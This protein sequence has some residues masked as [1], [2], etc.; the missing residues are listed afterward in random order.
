MALPEEPLSIPDLHCRSRSSPAH[1]SNTAI[2]LN[3]SRCDMVRCL[4]F[5]LLRTCS[6]TK[7]KR[8]SEKVENEKLDLWR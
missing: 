4:S 6:K 2:P 5:S 1:Y 8:R 7:K 3:Y